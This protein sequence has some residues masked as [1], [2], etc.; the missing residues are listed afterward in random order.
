MK[1]RFT[2][3]AVLM[4]ALL[5]ATACGNGNDG[6][7]DRYATNKAGERLVEKIIITS[8]DDDWFEV[9]SITYNPDGTVKSL[10][11]RDED[12]DK[13][14]LYI[15]K[16]NDLITFSGNGHNYTYQA[17]FT[18]DGNELVKHAYYQSV[19]APDDEFPDGHKD[20]CTFDFVYDK[21]NQLRSIYKNDE[22]IREIEW[23]NGNI[24][25]WKEY[26]DW[27]GSEREYDY[28]DFLPQSKHSNMDWGVY[29]LTMVLDNQ[30]YYTPYSLLPSGYLG[31]KG[32]DL[33]LAG[34]RGD[35][36][37]GTYKWDYDFDKDGYVSTIRVYYGGEL[38]WTQNITYLK[39]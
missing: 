14:T 36:G 9:D 34:S 3:P 37:E 7:K 35:G 29:G 20:S 2:L 23:A 1:L 18:L 5:M 13:E 10:T 21:N 25:N 6:N 4:A 30:L 39:K 19:E 16:K 33:L 38:S 15:E 31:Q 24:K 17:K 26:D 27:D 12:G 32:K 8:N 11:R 28:E 22:I